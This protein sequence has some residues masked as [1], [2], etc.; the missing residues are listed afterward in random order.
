MSIQSVSESQNFINLSAVEHV[1]LGHT[2]CDIYLVLEDKFE[3]RVT[4][5]YPCWSNIVRIVPHF[6]NSTLNYSLKKGIVQQE[7]FCP[8]YSVRKFFFL[9]CVQTLLFKSYK[10]SSQ[11][12]LSKFSCHILF[13]KGDCFYQLAKLHFDG[14][15]YLCRL[16]AVGLGLHTSQ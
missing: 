15:P 10:V 12:Y 13:N 2:L 5:K 14:E 7:S 1:I 8:G 11:G 6:I 3:H 9:I 16:R 4:V